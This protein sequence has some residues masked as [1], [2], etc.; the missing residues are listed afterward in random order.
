MVIAIPRRQHRERI[1]SLISVLGKETSLLGCRPG[2]EKYAVNPAT[3]G[4]N[5]T[6]ATPI[7]E[8]EEL[9]RHGM[10]SLEGAVAAS[11]LEETVLVC[12]SLFFLIMIPA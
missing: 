4:H 3:V 7:L 12:L 6:R 9:C 1:V 5:S 10:R 8:M 11:E 2:A